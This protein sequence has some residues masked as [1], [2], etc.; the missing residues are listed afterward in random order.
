MKDQK[1]ASPQ[2]QSQG[3]QLQKQQKV[4]LKL[5][6]IDN[7]P[8][9]SW[10]F[11]EELAIHSQNGPQIRTVA[12]APT[13][14]ASSTQGAKNHLHASSSKKISSENQKLQQQVDWS[15]NLNGLAQFFP[16]VEVNA[17]AHQIRI[18]A[19]MAQQQKSKQLQEQRQKQTAHKHEA[20]TQV[21]GKKLAEQKQ[22]ALINQKLDSAPI[23]QAKNQIPAIKQQES[24]SKLGKPLLNQNLIARSNQSVHSQ[25]NKSTGSSSVQLSAKTGNKQSSPKLKGN[26]GNQ[27]Q[28]EDWSSNLQG[29]TQLFPEQNINGSTHQVRIVSPQA[30]SAHHNASSLKLPK[31]Q[32][33]SAIRSQADKPQ[34]AQDWALNLNGLEQLFPDV[35]VHTVGHQ[36]RIPAQKLNNIA[37]QQQKFPKAQ[38]ATVHSKLNKTQIGA[39]WSLNLNGIGQL[40][41]EGII[42]ASGHQT[43]IP[44]PSQNNSSHQQEKLPRAQKLSELPIRMKNVKSKA[45]IELDWSLNLNGVGQLFTEG[46]I[47]ASGH[48]TRIPAPSQ[49]NSVSHQQQQK[50]PRAQKLSELPMKMKKA[51]QDYSADLSG[52][53]SLF[54]QV[55]VIT[56][57]H[58]IRIVSNKQNR[59]KNLEEVTSKRGEKNSVLQGKEHTNFAKVS[60]LNDK[61]NR[62]DSKKSKLVKE[63][64]GVEKIR[65]QNSLSVKQFSVSKDFALQNSFGDKIVAQRI[66]KEHLSQRGSKLSKFADP[67]SLNDHVNLISGGSSKLNQIARTEVWRLQQENFL[68][69]ERNQRSSLVEDSCT[70][71]S[72]MWKYQSEFGLGMD[73]TNNKGSK[74]PSSITFFKHKNSLQELEKALGSSNNLDLFRA[75]GLSFNR[76]RPSDGQDYIMHH[77]FHGSKAKDHIQ[78]HLV[79]SLHS[80]SHDNQRIHPEDSSLHGANVSSHMEIGIGKPHPKSDWRGLL[81]A[82]LGMIQIS[83]DFSTKGCSSSKAGYMKRKQNPTHCVEAYNLFLETSLDSYASIREAIRAQT[84]IGTKVRYENALK[85]AIGWRKH[86]FDRG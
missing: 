13:S 10:L 54:S 23:A 29:L 82:I 59:V 30:A 1:K 86:I 84:I 75:F 63:V 4:A 17:S 51:E 3:G 39:D 20:I 35:N 8:S 81:S 28:L 31:A 77:N 52:F 66:Q 70:G 79:E 61:N 11:P 22:H 74:M 69:D 33:M 16:E 78:S 5:D 67:S 47:N 55:P 85:E 14:K 40:F 26:K 73:R 37:A 53:A 44:A 65:D 27:I 43:R 19:D 34:L 21:G 24:N 48:Q 6:S 15:S 72:G 38:Q 9:L 80:N 60:G 76:D 7:V 57:E 50:F 68:E 83:R 64:R 12:K 36:T 56:K 58:Q 25:A 62:L 18:L 45:Q 2:Q 71:K 49:N 32:N 42:N 41:S 46:V